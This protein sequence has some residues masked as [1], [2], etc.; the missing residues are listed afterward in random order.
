MANKAGR[1]FDR[2]NAFFMVLGCVTIVALLA[3]VLYGVLMRYAFKQP[4]IWTV[5]VIEYCLL[6][7]TFIGASW[8]AR[9]ETWHVRNTMIISL[10]KER[11]Q[12][13]VNCITSLISSIVMLVI[14]VFGASVTWQGIQYN[15]VID[16]PLRP[17]EYV[18][19]ISVP[20]GS[21]MLS[22]QFLRNS[23]GYFRVWKSS[24]NGDNVRSG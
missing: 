13:C 23:W 20:V 17:P 6:Y 16:T 21:L 22:I 9:T 8:V 14:A 4:K 24:E 19:F 1:V 2:A 7:I 18:L 12:A 10:L 3:I 15:Y 5:E 11:P